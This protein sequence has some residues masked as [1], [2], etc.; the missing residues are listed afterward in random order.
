MTMTSLKT[1]AHNGVKER[2]LKAFKSKKPHVETIDN[3]LKPPG[4]PR[5]SRKSIVITFR[6]N[7]RN[8]IKLSNIEPGDHKDT[9]KEDIPD[10]PYNATYKKY[11][12]FGRRNNYYF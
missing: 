9:E 2:I 3:N 8:S 4:S 11:L 7:G 10:Y 5:K 12:E 1:N 6:R